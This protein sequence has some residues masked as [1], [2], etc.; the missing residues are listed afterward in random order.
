MTGDFRIQT[1]IVKQVRTRE[2][3]LNAFELM[4]DGRLNPTS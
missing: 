4:F 3:A 1:D 2:L